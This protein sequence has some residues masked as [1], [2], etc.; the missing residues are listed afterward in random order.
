[1]KFW[2]LGDSHS[3][4]ESNRLIG[5]DSDLIYIVMKMKVKCEEKNGCVSDEY[6]DRGTLV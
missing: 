5:V 3:G 4:D 6:L 2:S 1:M